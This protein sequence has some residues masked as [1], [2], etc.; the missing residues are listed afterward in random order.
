MVVEFGR[1]IVQLV[2]LWGMGIIWMRMHTGVMN[3]MTDMRY[4]LEL[5]KTLNSL[6]TLACQYIAKG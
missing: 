3:T 4:V 2:R 5:K 6:G 1:G